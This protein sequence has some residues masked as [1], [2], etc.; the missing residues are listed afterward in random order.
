MEFS[1]Q[2]T[3]LLRLWAHHL[4]YPIAGIFLNFSSRSESLRVTTSSRL[5]AALHPL[6]E[7]WGCGGWLSPSPPGELMWWVFLELC[8][9]PYL[10]VLTVPSLVFNLINCLTLSLS[11]DLVTTERPLAWSLTV[12][13]GRKHLIHDKFIRLPGSWP[14]KMVEDL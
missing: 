3:T 14:M 8:V 7:G 6:Q 12:H 10:W 1:W 13:T 2:T 11:P 9:N 5:S 4:K